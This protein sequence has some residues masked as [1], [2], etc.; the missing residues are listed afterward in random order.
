MFMYNKVHKGLECLSVHRYQSLSLRAT[1]KRSESDTRWLATASRVTTRGIPGP[2][3]WAVRIC[4]SPS[5]AKAVGSASGCS[6]RHSATRPPA[7]LSSAGTMECQNCLEGFNQLGRLPKTVPCGHTACLWCLRSVKGVDR[8]Q[9]PT[10]R[11]VFDI[12]PDT[13]PTNSTLL[14]LIVGADRSPGS[15]S[16]NWRDVLPKKKAASTKSPTPPPAAPSPAPPRPAEEMYV[17]DVSQNGP[18]QRQQEKAKL[19]AEATGLVI[20]HTPSARFSRINYERPE[21]VLNP[22]PSDLRANSEAL[23][24]CAR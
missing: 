3:Y 4:A 22:R 15:W 14:R 24:H 7:R 16:S 12:P 11:R 5:F 20:S 17:D 19:L 18:N 6:V 13:L 21:W 8:T 9:C 23:S 2:S 10:C 1:A